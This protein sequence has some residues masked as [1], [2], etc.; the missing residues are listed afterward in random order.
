MENDQAKEIYCDNEEQET[1]PLIQGNYRVYWYRWYVLLLFILFWI[2]L[3]GST[4]LW[5][6]INVSTERALGFQKSD[7]DL[8]A[9]WGVV[10][11]VIFLPVGLWLLMKFGLRTVVVS[12]ASL[13][14]VGAGLRCLPLGE[15]LKYAIHVGQ[16]L[17]GI[18]GSAVMGVAPYISSAWF[19]CK[20]RVFATG[21]MLLSGNL[22]GS[23]VYVLGP[24][25]VEVPH[26]SS[27]SSSD[28][29]TIRCEILNYMYLN[30]GMI[31]F[32]FLLMLIYFPSKPPSPPSHSA[33]LIRLDFVTSIKSLIRNRTYWAIVIIFDGV[34]GSFMAW[35]G[36][37][38]VLYADK[39][40]SETTSGWIGAALVLFGTIVGS[41]IGRLAD[42]VPS[43]RTKVF[44]ITLVLSYISCLYIVVM[45]LNWIPVIPF[46]FSEIGLWV[47]SMIAGVSV[48]ALQPV[49]MEMALDVAY[50][51][52][53]GVAGY[54][55][56]WITM[57][58][59]VIF[60]SVLT[61][62]K[63]QDT[64][65]YMMFAFLTSALPFAFF[66]IPKTYQRLNIDI[67]VADK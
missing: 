2:I 52:G 28:T 3:T 64:A 37:M 48:Y 40:I 51:V 17:T 31:A 53:E 57:L 25:L 39:E 1:L 29:T 49:A 7:F 55:L 21:L 5:S 13:G 6:P 33:A 4:A 46:K 45:S 41:A 9:N 61:V 24:Y 11:A 12:G 59:N 27:N 66:A 16:I 38:P 23:V 10:G 62:V 56:M 32:V 20:E 36:I 26:N 47:S 15:N 43:H 60:F 8:I 54:V 19:P 58:M 65:F 67:N 30:F 42:A 35:W 22:G 44:L 63:N 18:G 14:L 50:P 34:V